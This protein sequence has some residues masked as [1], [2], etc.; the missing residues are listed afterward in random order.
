M[1]GDGVTFMQTI[2]ILRMF[3]VDKAREF[4][5]DYL[6]F[7]IDFEHR[8]EPGFPLYMQISR[9]DL[10]L[11]LSEHYGD[12]SPGAAVFV[13]M[14]GIDALV[15]ELSA[16]QCPPVVEE[17]WGRVVRLLDPFGNRLNLCERLN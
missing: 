6:G 11:H 16:R 15:K 4:Y 2:P 12:G 9:G 14:K 10:V 3:D 1:T 8:F 13:R 17:P 5:I 7:T